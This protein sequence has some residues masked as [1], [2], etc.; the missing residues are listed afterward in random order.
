MDLTREEKTILLSLLNE[1]EMCFSYEAHQYEK[2]EHVGNYATR[3][4]PAMYRAK[5][6]KLA[7]LIAKLEG[8]T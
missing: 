4:L 5:A 2:L 1:K 8:M 6:E 3:D 7:R